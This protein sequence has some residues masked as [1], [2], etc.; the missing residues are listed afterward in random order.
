MHRFVYCMFGVLLM[1][2]SSYGQPTKTLNL[3]DILEIYCLASNDAKILEIR[4]TE[5]FALDRKF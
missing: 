1:V 5:Q 2:S 3:D 4:S